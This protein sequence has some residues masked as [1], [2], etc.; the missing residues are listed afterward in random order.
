[1]TLGGSGGLAAYVAQAS[2]SVHLIVDV[3]GYF[4]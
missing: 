1:V 4:E 3:S 2:G